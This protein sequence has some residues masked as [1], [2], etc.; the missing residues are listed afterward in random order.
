M[1]TFNEEHNKKKL[2]EYFC[3]GQ[4]IILSNMNVQSIYN[5]LQKQKEANN[6]K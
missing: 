2:I 5:E 6:Y 3:V 4:G 1:G